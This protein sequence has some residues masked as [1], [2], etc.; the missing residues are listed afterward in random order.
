MYEI[1]SNILPILYSP[2]GIYNYP[3]T[4]NETAFNYIN[5]LEKNVNLNNK[6]S[7]QSRVL[8]NESLSNLKSFIN[9]CIKDFL[10]KTYN[11]AHELEIYLT[12]SW[13]NY[14][15]KGDSHHL[16]NHPNSLI[17]GV[18]YI[19]TTDEDNIIFFRTETTNPFN[20]QAKGPTLFNGDSYKVPV[21]KNSLILFP[22]L[23]Y[24]YTSKHLSDST[25]ISLSFNT[26]VSG[27]INDSKTLQNLSLSKYV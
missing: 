10:I 17:S 12:D 18:F 13:I 24:H 21:L 23:I 14:N 26:F 16:H 3:L 7:K 8:E 6:S 2:L 25:R 4:L 27:V 5:S 15:E 11:P 19:N 20:I 9:F 1:K 22:S